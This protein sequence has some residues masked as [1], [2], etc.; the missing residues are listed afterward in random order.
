MTRYPLDRLHEEVAYIAYHL[1]WSR[2][3]I[4][5]LEHPERLRWVSEIGRLNVRLSEEGA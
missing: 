5:G 1:H 3:E 4:L 2:A